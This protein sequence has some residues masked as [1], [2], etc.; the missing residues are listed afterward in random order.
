MNGRFW[1]GEKI[2]RSWS[3]GEEKKGERCIAGVDLKMVLTLERRSEHVLLDDD[4][5]TIGEGKKG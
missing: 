1:G 4:L 5:M 3:T 2:D